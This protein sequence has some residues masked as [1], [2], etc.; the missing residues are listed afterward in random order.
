ME[1]GRRLESKIEAER[2]VAEA[3][4][5]V[6]RQSKLVATYERRHL[7]SRDARALLAQLERKLVEFE[8][9][10]AKISRTS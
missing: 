8:K 3:R 4:R 10:L 9:A 5:K 1:D 2:N 6:E 7:N